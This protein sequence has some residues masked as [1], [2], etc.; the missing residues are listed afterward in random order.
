VRST[1]LFTDGLANAGVTKAEDIGAAV[2]AK[3]GELGENRCTLSTF[4][5]GSDHDA[6]LL[7]GLAQKGEGVYS[8]IE[9]EDMIGQAFGEAMGGLSTTS[10]QNV[11]LSLQLAPGI[12]LAKAHTEFPVT[13]QDGVVDIALGDLFAEERK[14]ILLA[15]KLP[16][17]SSEGTSSVGVLRARGFCVLSPPRSE[18]TER[19]G[20]QL[21]RQSSSAGAAQDGHPQVIRHRNRHVATQA[22]ADARAAAMAGDLPGA[23]KL[24]QTASEILGK[25]SLA[26]AGDA[27]TLGL[28]TD[29]KDL[30]KDLEDKA[31]YH[32]V[33]S[34]KM[35]SMHSSHARQRASWGASFSEMYST[36]TMCTSK[37]YYGKSVR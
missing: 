30:L 19:L 3:L 34:K 31:T 17:A 29:L 26:V 36:Q 8:Y 13:Q 32:T 20:L 22:L 7:Q 33:G 12:S 15:L 28:L 25:S 10:H 11:E 18:E 16:E 24:L 23:R 21:E 9:N 27:L 6:E 14:D 35:A 4:G 1:F 5:F 37:E 2:V